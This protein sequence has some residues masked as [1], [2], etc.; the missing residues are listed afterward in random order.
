[1]ARA[2]GYGERVRGAFAEDGP[3]ARGHDDY[4]SRPQQEKLAQAIARALGTRG[5]TLVAHAPT[6]IGKTLAYLVPALESGGRVVVSTGTVPLQ[7][8]IAHRDLP[9]LQKLLDRPRTIAVLKGRAHYLCRFRLGRLLETPGLPGFS[10]ADVERLDLWAR[11]SDEGDLDH[12]P[13]AGDLSVLRS[14]VVTTAEACTGSACPAFADCFVYRARRRAQEADI[15]VINHHLLL[16][17]LLLKREGF[18]ALLPEADAFIVDEAHRLAD[19]LFTALAESYGAG[20]L[21]ELLHDARRGFGRPGAPERGRELVLRLEEALGRLFRNRSHRFET[22]ILPEDRSIMGTLSSL[23]AEIAEILDRTSPP[24]EESAEGASLRTRARA[25][26]DFF[27]RWLDADGEGSERAS[28]EEPT[29]RPEEAWTRALAWVEGEGRRSVFRLLAEDPRRTFSDLVRATG[30]S[31]VFLSATLAVAGRLEPFARQIGVEADEGLVLES[32]FDYA[33]QGLLYLPERL[34]AVNAPDYPEAYLELLAALVRETDGG[35]FLLFTSRQALLTAAEGLRTLL[36]AS[37]RLLVQG[38]GSRTGLLEEFRRDGHAVLVATQTFWE[39]VDVPG[40]ALRLVA[41][42]RLPFASPEDPLSRIKGEVA[43]REGD[44]PFQ[45]YALPQAVV[46]LC[47]GVGRLIR[48]EDDRGLVVVGD[49]RLRTA[50]YRRA[51]LESLPPFRRTGE[52]AVVR[53]FL[54]ALRASSGT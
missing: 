30:A 27:A 52:R 15:V 10:G 9:R 36:G 8:Q 1:M 45:R 35:A 5:E 49:T 3:I 40:A 25:A 6:G 11:H 54:E 7:D 33:R 37:R 38:T 32:P 41:I 47:Q 53:A 23:L 31:W 44:D 28:A 50:S 16:T 17:D 48:H 19:L 26:S 42:D 20:R 43:R 51:F 14:Q 46:S 2:D 4:R 29:A 18:G 34:P 39:G 21:E 12:Y 24:V 22:R 13:D